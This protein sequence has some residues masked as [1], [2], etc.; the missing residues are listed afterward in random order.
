MRGL[1]GKIVV[2][3]GGG[4]GIGSATCRRFAEEGARIVVADINAAA[5]EKVTEEIK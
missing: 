4:G 3:T 2:V 5:A 1:K